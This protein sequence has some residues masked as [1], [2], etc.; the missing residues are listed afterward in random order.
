MLSD[1]DGMLLSRS[2]GPALG[3]DVWYHHLLPH[4]G[5]LLQA[6]KLD[7]D[8]IDGHGD[9]LFR[10]HEGRSLRVLDLVGGFGAGLLGHGRT[11]L[12]EAG[13]AALRHVPLL[14]QVSRR[15]AAAD[16][17]RRLSDWF[18]SVTGRSY[19]C[20]LHSTG[21]EAVDAALKHA[22]FRWKAT[23]QDR[24]LRIQQ[25][26]GSHAP[27]LIQECLDYNR[28]AIQGCRPLVIAV[29]RSYHGKASG[30]LNVT[31]DATERSPFAELLGARVQFVPRELLAQPQPILTEILARETVLLREP[32]VKNGAAEILESPFRTV[33]A[34][35]V[36]PIQGE[37]G[38]FEVP[39]AWLDALHN[40]RIPVIADEIQCGL[41]RSG[42]FPASRGVAAEYYLIGKSLGGGI[43]KISATLI[44]QS[45]YCEE[46]DLHTGATFSGDPFSSQVALKVLEIIQNEQIADRCRGLGERF[47]TK[48]ECVR[49]EFPELVRGISGRG[50]MLGIWLGVP[51]RLNTFLHGVMHERLGYVAASY[52]LHV[53]HIRVLPT[54]SAPSILRLEPSA[55]LADADMDQFV[56]ALRDYCQQLAADVS[57]LFRHLVFEPA[58]GNL[59]RCATMGPS[60]ETLQPPMR[61]IGF[62]FV[63]EPPAVGARRVG[64]IF[65]SLYPANEL[66]TVIPELRT[67]SAGQRMELAERLQQLLQLQ[68]E[69]FFSKNLFGNRVWLHGIVLPAS[70]Q[71]LESFSRSDSI[72][73]VRQQ[74]QRALDMAADSGCQTVVF[75]AQTSVVTAAATTLHP[76]PGVQIASG[77][78][79]TVAVVLEQ[80]A[81]AR[82]RLNLSDSGRI[83]VV[84]AGGN[85]GAALARWFALRHKHGP[86]L[87]LGRAGSLSRVKDLQSEL[88]AAAQ[89]RTLNI[90]DDPNALR[91]CDLIVV[92]VSGYD[93][94]VHSCHV[95]SDRAVLIADVSQPQA[96]CGSVCENRPNATLIRA[97]L[98]RLPEDRD[99]R[100]TPHTHR[101]TCFACTAEGLLMGLEP[102]PQLRLNGRIALEA[103]HTL[104]RLGRKYRMID[105][106]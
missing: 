73:L 6:L 26:C 11:E 76:P 1:F 20:L 82:R 29:E 35:I 44:D 87:L 64:F 38:I 12:Q 45:E 81:A 75:G 17:A 25:T 101:G 24:M 9:C 78:T 62:R 5:R 36:E 74:L 39:P 33:M 99:V 32:V 96:V 67:W 93:P 37:G 68:P 41:G 8:Y 83:G 63:Q 42:E 23:F 95:G 84:G 7:V 90:T 2:S 97:G 77:N 92:A 104:R 15:A 21:A 80:I 102:H 65:N 57:A 14:D 13:I 30:A 66:Q 10:L 61:P 19:I 105:E 18:G 48:L 70:P 86:L 69:T 71:M 28:R 89:H 47:R 52:L 34:A 56:A 79:F 3:D 91:S 58:G 4:V 31:S 72:G 85:I 98:V 43:A 40:A 16:L 88:A 60:T 53:H 103:V 94:I 49:R 22:L 106:A 46:F 50:A 27:G 55:Y 54:L 51:D 59:A 100:L